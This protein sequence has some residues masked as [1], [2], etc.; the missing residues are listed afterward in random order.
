M[1]FAFE[2][3]LIAVAILLLLAVFSSK[4]TSRFG[5]PIL[6][7]FL[8]IGML[9]GSDGIGRIYFDNAQLAQHL[10]IVALVMILF[11]GGLETDSTAVR[12]VLIRGISLSTIGVIATALFTGAFAWQ[13]LQLPLLES[14]LLG[15]IMSSTDAAAVFAVLRARRISLRGSLRPLLELES[16]SNDPTAVFLVTALIT[17]IRTPSTAP[18]LHAVLWFIMQMGI[19]ALSGIVL[20]RL[21]VALINRLDLEHDALYPIASVSLVLLSYGL[22][23]VLGGNGFIAVYLMGIIMGNARLIRKRSIRKFH[24]ITAWLMQITMFITLGLLVFPSKLPGI[25]VNALL[26]SF[27]L[28][29]IARPV[30]VGLSLLFARIPVREHL[31]ISWVGLRGATPIILATF[32]LMAGISSADIMFNVVFFVV[33]TSVLIQ[34]TTIPLVAQLLKLDEPL[35]RREKIPIELDETNYFHKELLEVQVPARSPI[36]GKKIMELSLPG[37]TLIVLINKGNNNYVTPR[38]PTEIEAHD[39]ILMLIKKGMKKE[40][41]T[42]LGN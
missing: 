15:S 38:G 1:Q 10:G 32:P 23:T 42:A 12:P 27:F 37:D 16:G 22:A 28:M 31:M 39:R 24:D 29:F 7:S 3:V 9:A 5:V 8:I 13:F 41:R 2:Y 11:S 6:L 35:T 25:A 30:S 18:W 26:L 20:G 33:M 19:G 21:A 34:G 40:V 14:L 36:I 4:T 17:L